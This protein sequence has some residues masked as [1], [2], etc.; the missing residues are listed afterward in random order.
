MNNNILLKEP[1]AIFEPHVSDNRQLPFIFHHYNIPNHDFANFH[2]NLELLYFR[3]G[4]G[5]VKYDDKEITVAKG[6]VIVVNSF[7]THKIFAEDVIELA[8]LIIDNDF[9]KSHSV[10]ATKLFFSPHL[11]D[12]E[13]VSFFEKIICLYHNENEQ[14]RNF[15]LKCAVLNLLLYLCVNFSSYNHQPQSKYYSCDYIR[16]A[17]EYIKQNFSKKITADEVANQVGLSKFH[18]LREFK[19]QTGFTLTNY[20]NAIRCEH[21]KNLLSSGK[22][23]VKKA[24]ILCGFHNFSYFTNLFKKHTN[25]LPSEYLKK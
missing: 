4:N 21:A 1:D 13:L 9:C 16:L 11:N 19:K 2:E 17:I 5:Y 25:H 18:F 14:F 15:K 24:A 22:Y 20:I 10:D 3:K 23:S 12:K 7:T 8:C 6:D